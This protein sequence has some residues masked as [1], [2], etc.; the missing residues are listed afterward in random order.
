MP[1]K[2]KAARSARRNGLSS[3]QKME[4]LTGLAPTGEGFPDHAAYR[5]AWWLHRAA[6]LAEAA[7]FTRPEAFWIL[8][9]DYIPNCRAN[10]YESERV[11]LSRLKLP[12]TPQELSILQNEERKTK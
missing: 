2:R 12:L 11:A 8:E 1:R 10:G 9:Y 4:L 3:G 5:A 6:L 7:P